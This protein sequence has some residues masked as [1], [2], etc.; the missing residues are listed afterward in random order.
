M[1]YDKINVKPLY[2]ATGIECSMDMV[3]ELNDGGYWTLE[4]KKH[5]WK[6]VVF[7]KHDDTSMKIC[8]EGFQGPDDP[9]P[10]IHVDMSLGEWTLKLDC[11]RVE[12]AWS[13]VATEYAREIWEG[14][15]NQGWEVSN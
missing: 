10:M 3:R 11:D 14:L 8:G 15:I 13:A 6:K 2:I 12:G 1:M 9:P 5:P 4:W 7:T